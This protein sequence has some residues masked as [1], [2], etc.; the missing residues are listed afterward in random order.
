[1]RIFNVFFIDDYFLLGNINGNDW[2][3]LHCIADNAVNKIA[4]D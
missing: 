3:V 2:L 4:I 1:M